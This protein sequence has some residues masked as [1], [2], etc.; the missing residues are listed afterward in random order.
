VDGGVAPDDRLDRD[1]ISR[2]R[3]AMRSTVDCPLVEPGEETLGEVLDRNDV[4]GRV[5]LTDGL[6][7]STE[8]AGRL[9]DGAGRLG[10]M[11]VLGL[12]GLRDGPGE[13][14]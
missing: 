14:G 10:A 7:R 5:G 12:L 2:R 11:E 13:T 9:N 8:G 4:G 1:W 6:D 3:V